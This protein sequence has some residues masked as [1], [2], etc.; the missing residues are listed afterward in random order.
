MNDKLNKQ[1]N[2]LTNE[3]KKHI[4]KL[5]DAL[6]PEEELALTLKVKMTK[7]EYKLFNTWAKGENLKAL[8]EKLSIDEERYQSMQEKLIKKIN[9]EK[10]KQGIML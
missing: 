2:L 10:F 3:L 9:Q 6:K 7:K 8:L 4:R 1:E 5:P